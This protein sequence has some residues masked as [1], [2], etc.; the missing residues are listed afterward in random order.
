[1]RSWPPW[2]PPSGPWS[3]GSPTAVA[4]TSTWRSTCAKALEA[5]LFG[6]HR[7]VLINLVEIDD[8]EFCEEL[9]GRADELLARGQRKL[10]E[11]LEITAGRT[12][13]A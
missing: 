1:L 13:D 4:S 9:T 10:A 6:S 2:A 8:E 12:G 3:A 11:L 7:N 5:G